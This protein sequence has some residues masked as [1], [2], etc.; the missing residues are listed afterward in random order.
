M[1]HV[2]QG[3]DAYFIRI[4]EIRMNGETPI[5]KAYRFP[6]GHMLRTNAFTFNGDLT[7][8]ATFRNTATNLLV[9]DMEGFSFSV[10]GDL[11][12]STGKDPR[13]V[14]L[15]QCSLVSLLRLRS[16]SVFHV[17]SVILHLVDKCGN[18]HCRQ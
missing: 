6:M 3:R 9:T 15:N 18:S 17:A 16:H 13:G 11:Y 2:Q 10:T 4:N 7:F 14:V 1:E 8:V 12:G 5:S